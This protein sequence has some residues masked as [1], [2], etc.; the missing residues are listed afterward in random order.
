MTGPRKSPNLTTK[1]A[2]TLLRVK[3]ESGAWLI[4]EP[5]R[6][7]GSAKMIVSL[8]DFDHCVL[9]AIGGGIEAQNL[10]PMLRAEHREKSRTDTGKAAKVKR[11]TATQEE[12]RRVILAR[13]RGGVAD[14]EAGKKR[15][16][17]KFQNRG[18]DKTHT[19]RFNGKVTPKCQSLK[20]N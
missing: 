6:S 7:S 17:A 14:I 5:Y 16:K 18:F 20:S 13:V 12:H 11:I 19:K 10:Y 15:P 4:P 8:V 2:A 9:H 3:S 1:L